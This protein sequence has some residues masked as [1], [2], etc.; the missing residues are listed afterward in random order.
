MSTT[1][2]HEQNTDTDAPETPASIAEA[3]RLFTAPLPLSCDFRFDEKTASVFDDMVSRSVPMYHEIQRMSGEIAADFAVPG[4]R[5]VDLGCATGT[6]LAYLDPVIDPEV[7][8]V[9]VDN[10][11]DM[12]DKA[13]QKL[14]QLGISRPLE[15][16]NADLHREQV[17]EDASVA[18]LN[19]TLQ[20]IRPLYRE[21]VI[22]NIFAG[23]QD[24]GALILVEKLTLGDSMFN[25]LFIRYYY[26]MKRRNG[27]SE[28]EISQKREALENVL[29]PYRPDENLEL[30]KGA[31]FKH[32]E[33][34][35]RWYNFSGIVAVK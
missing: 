35:F 10:A 26:D 17:V 23:L 28:V 7:T 4:T 3:D 12:L 1:D 20:F 16:I 8:F 13:R 21:R 25:R 31:G 18:V 29:I 22:G 30:L 32:V 11:D 24:Q 34:F 6:T 9:G 14:T 27:Y 15:F 33:E 2:K 19:L 5:L